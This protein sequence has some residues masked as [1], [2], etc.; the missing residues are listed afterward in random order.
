MGKEKE[1]Y[2][3][4]ADKIKSLKKQ[5]PYLR[6]KT[7]DYVFSVLCIKATF[8]KNS[9]PILKENDFADIVVNGQHDG[10]ADILL[11]DPNSDSAYLVI[12]QSKFYKTIRTEDVLNAMLKM[13]RFYNDMLAGHYEQVSER[14][15]RRF[16]K[17][18][19]D[20]GDESKIRFIF[21]TSALQKRIDKKYIERKFCEQFKNS[22]V[23]EVSILFAADVVEEVKE[24]E[25]IKP[26]V[27]YGKIHIDEKNN[28]LLYGE[29]AV[30][31]N[32]SAFSLKQLYA[33]HNKSL[34]A[35]NLRYH[36]K[37]GKIDAN[38]RDTIDKNPESFWMKN[39]GI[40][41][42]CD[43]FELDG[44]E[45]KL[46]NFSIVNGGQTTYVIH[47]SKSI[48]AIHDLWLP[49]KI[50]KIKGDSEDEKSAFSLEIAR[51]ANDQKAITPAD[52][53]AN[54]PEQ[55]RFARIMREMG[56][57]YQ[58]KRGEE[59]PERFRIAYLNTKLPEVGK[60]CLAAIFQEPCKSRTNPSA[61]Y[62][63]KYK[64]RYYTPIFNANQKQIAA[65][66]KELL[67]ID[68]YFLKKF[69]PKFEQEN[70]NKLNSDARIAFA[71]LSRRICVAFTALAAR[72]YQHNITEKDLMTLTTEQTDFSYK[73]FRN[74]NELKALLPIKLYTEAYDRALDKLFATIINAGARMYSSE[75]RRS[76]TLTVTNFMKKDENYYLILKEYWDYLEPKISETFS[77]V[78]TD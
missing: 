71:R 72:Y 73:A 63:D 42:T 12:G 77:D 57:L 4:I 65:I 75:S 7:D 13:A 69:L 53:K 2:S 67:Y 59:I 46:W 26:I 22:N 14:V 48:D 43:K 6:S 78:Q 30:I 21:Y 64:D 10:G 41:I 47:S 52:L 35:R 1:M 25:S 23:I 74:L 76:P 45:V 54:A 61:S 55:V 40:T 18:S 37:G 39:N 29:E 28:Y 50:I 20:V 38:I 56:I 27:E 60:L 9:E 66:C 36:I 8:D 17:L 34:L 16:I 31:V 11:T 58:T 70:K 24:M 33:E 32:V 44:N 68:D 49:C 62:N 51:A 3:Y 19:D 15:Q 5:Y